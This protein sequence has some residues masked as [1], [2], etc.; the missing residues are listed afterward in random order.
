MISATPG[1][2]VPDSRIRAAAISTIR[3]WFLALSSCECPS[4]HQYIWMMRIILR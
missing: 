2:A 4:A 1:A 3:S